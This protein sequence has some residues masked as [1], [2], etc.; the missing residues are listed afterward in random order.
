MLIELKAPTAMINPAGEIKTFPAGT[1][2]NYA[3][4]AAPGGQWLHRIMHMTAKGTF[5][6]EAVTEVG[7][8]PTWL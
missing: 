7:G 4:V 3:R 6:L 8:V 5:R 2:V 1:R